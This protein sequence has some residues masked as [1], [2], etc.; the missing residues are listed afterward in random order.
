LDRR[1]ILLKKVESKKWKVKSRVES[2][3][4]QAPA[5]RPALVCLPT[6]LLTF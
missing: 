3:K 4:G 1:V 6:F 2:E 5:G